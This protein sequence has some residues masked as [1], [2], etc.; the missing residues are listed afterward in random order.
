MNIFQPFTLLI[1]YNPSLENILVKRREGDRE[2]VSDCAEHRDHEPLSLSIPY[3]H[4]VPERRQ[5]PASVALDSHWW[6]EASE[7]RGSRSDMD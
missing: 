5:Q 7:I 6:G 1:I 3:W 2:L 4:E